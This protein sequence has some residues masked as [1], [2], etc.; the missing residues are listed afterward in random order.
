MSYMLTCNNTVR[1][2]KRRAQSART[3]N[4]P[5]I[6]PITGTVITRRSVA[7]VAR[8][9]ASFWRPP[10]RDA[11]PWR[12]AGGGYCSCLFTARASCYA[13]IIRPGTAGGPRRQGQ[14]RGTRKI[15]IAPAASVPSPLPLPS[16]PYA[17]ENK[18]GLI[19]T[20]LTCGP[21]LEHTYIRSFWEIIR[22]ETTSRRQTSRG[23]TQTPATRLISSGDCIIYVWLSVKS[24]KIKL[25]LVFYIIYAFTMRIMWKTQSPSRGRYIFLYY[26]DIRLG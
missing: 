11:G 6:P 8:A 2:R 19:R 13:G 22:N 18:Q 24:R 25:C 23:I 14:G 1:V 17:Y 21:G 3:N 5:M 7:A 26:N 20:N 15:V 10:D 4:P 9:A 16:L 12:R